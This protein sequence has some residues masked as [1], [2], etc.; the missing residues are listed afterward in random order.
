MNEWAIFDKALSGHLDDALNCIPQESW[1]LIQC[2]GRSLLELCYTM[3]KQ[4]N[5]R[6]LLMLLKSDAGVMS[7]RE[8][9]SHI[10]NVL[11]QGMR[12][13][14]RILCASGPFFPW[15]KQDHSHFYSGTHR[16]ALEAA[17]VVLANGVRLPKLAFHFGRIQEDD[18]ELVAFD[19]GVVNL[20]RI[21]TT[22]L[23]IKRFRGR[24]LV[25]VDRFLFREMALAIWVTRYEF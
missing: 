3:K 12:D 6:A 14:A 1:D 23:G 21:C 19:A 15:G 24:S 8:R 22:F 25:H 7:R 4:P 9:W 16:N 18:P 20:Q 10:K 13:T 5:T 17:K 11:H 2:R